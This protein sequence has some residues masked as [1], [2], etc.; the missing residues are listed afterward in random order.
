M[1]AL[2]YFDV[3]EDGVAAHAAGYAQ[4]DC[5]FPL[6]S[7]EGTAWARSWG[8]AEADA[9]SVAGTYGATDDDY[10]AGGLKPPERDAAGRPRSGVEQY[11]DDYLR[12]LAAAYAKELARVAR[13][14][15]S[16]A[17]DLAQHF[18]RQM[19]IPVHMIRGHHPG[20]GWH[21]APPK[22]AAAPPTKLPAGWASNPADALTPDPAD[23]VLRRYLVPPPAVPAPELRLEGIRARV[24]PAPPRLPAQPLRPPKDLPR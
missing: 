3:P 7:P 9:R 1:T 16:T 23:A 19:G 22:S 24:R 21:T 11:V 20:P 4:A 8:L 14:L 2:D 5:P 6:G 15:T 18:A 17:D 10:R 12:A 13:I